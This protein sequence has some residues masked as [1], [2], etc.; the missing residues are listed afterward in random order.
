MPG[1]Q[2]KIQLVLAARVQP[3]ENPAQIF[4]MLVGFCRAP[5]RDPRHGKCF[6]PGCRRKRVSARKVSAAI[7]SVVVGSRLR[8]VASRS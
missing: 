3:V 5:N 1:A 4:T 6:R 8:S 7:H 2:K